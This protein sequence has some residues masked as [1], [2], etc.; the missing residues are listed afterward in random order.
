MSGNLNADRFNNFEK[1]YGVFTIKQETS[2]QCEL[3]NPLKP[4]TYFM[5]QQL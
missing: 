5:H 1:D 2:L 3:L 4:K